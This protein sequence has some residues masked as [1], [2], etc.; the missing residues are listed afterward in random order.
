MEGEEGSEPHLEKL[1]KVLKEL[2]V[3]FENPRGLPPLESVTTESLLST[4][5]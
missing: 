4:H 1:Q 3:V 5:S 2:S